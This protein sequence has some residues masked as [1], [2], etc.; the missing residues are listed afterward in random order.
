MTRRRSA[1][2][3]GGFPSRSADEDE[4][5]SRQIQNAEFFISTVWRIEG[6]R[7]TRRVYKV[8]YVTL[9]KPVKQFKTL[10]GSVYTVRIIVLYFLFL[11][12]LFNRNDAVK[13]GRSTFN[14][15]TLT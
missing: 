8:S 11:F 4:V 12:F 13:T 3:A 9:F 1:R 5:F 15:P 2:P 14:A 7:S 10:N 6:T